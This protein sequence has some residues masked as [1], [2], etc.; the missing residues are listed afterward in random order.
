MK[1][2]TTRSIHLESLLA[3]CEHCRTPCAHLWTFAS[4]ANVLQAFSGDQGRQVVSGRLQ[5][6]VKLVE[7]M[8]TEQYCGHP[9]T[10]A[11]HVLYCS[12]CNV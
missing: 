8:L 11:E 4:L 6:N 10:I 3:L 1:E 5:P 12:E 9:N 2:E 7:K